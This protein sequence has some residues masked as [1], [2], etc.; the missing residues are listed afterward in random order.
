MSDDA[1]RLRLGIIGDGK[2]GRSIAALAAERDIE[3]LAMLTEAENEDAVAIEAGRL[4]GVDVAVEFTEPRSAVA[5]ALACVRAHIPVVV[6]TTGWH[7]RLPEV[8]KVVERENGSLLWAPNFSV[9]V[10]LFSALVEMA[11][12]LFASDYTDV[13]V[14]ET[15]HAAKKDAPSGTALSLANAFEAGGGRT[16]P[17]TSVR[18]G[19]VPGTHEVVLDAPFEQV[20]L[21]HAARDRRV[22]ADGALRA[23]TWL[24]GRRGVFTM[25]DV[26]GLEPERNS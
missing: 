11:G 19:H 20:R 16:P 1:R 24:N 25:R 23:A 21:V 10:V 9:G 22:F 15:H 2:M 8:M 14:I 6:G 13:H 26:L 7:D 4:E 5:N 3:V 17:I 18:T 12:R